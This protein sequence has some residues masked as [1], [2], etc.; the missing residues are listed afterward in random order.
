MEIFVD[1]LLVQ[2]DIHYNMIEN[3][4][5]FHFTMTTKSQNEIQRLNQLQI[6]I[7]NLKCVFYSLNSS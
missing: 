7:P 2:K 3:N 4:F 6:N 1:G 5:R